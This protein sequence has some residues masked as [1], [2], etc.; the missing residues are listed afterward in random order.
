MFSEHRRVYALPFAHLFSRRPESRLEGEVV[1]QCILPRL[2]SHCGRAAVPSTAFES[3]EPF[4]ELPITPLSLVREINRLVSALR[5]GVNEA[6]HGI[7]EGLL[8]LSKRLR[9]PSNPAQHP[10]SHGDARHN[11]MRFRIGAGSFE[12]AHPPKDTTDDEHDPSR[13][14]LSLPD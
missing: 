14:A 5:H 9:E 6:K 7:V 4:F 13:P 12:L 3:K 2:G 1:G 8:G 10:A 11:P